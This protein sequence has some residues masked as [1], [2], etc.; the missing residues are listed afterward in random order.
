MGAD[1]LTFWSWSTIQAP[2]SATDGLSG[3]SQYLKYQPDLVITDL[4]MPRL[5]WGIL[6]PVEFIADP[7]RGPSVYLPIIRDPQP[8]HS[9][10]SRPK[11]VRLRLSPVRKA[12]L[13]QCV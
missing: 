12:R 9:G 1:W 6:T 8:R 4:V 3:L 10:A 5:H 13:L 11:Q 7:S 2:V